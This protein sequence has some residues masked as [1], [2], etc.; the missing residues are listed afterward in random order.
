[1][2]QMKIIALTLLLA[3]TAFAADPAVEANVVYGMY[4]GAALL[5]DVHRPASPN[6][7]GIIYVSGSGWTSRWPTPRLR[8]SPTG[9]R[10]NMPSRWWRPDTPSSR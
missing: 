9:S 1:M 6:G 3:T 7:Y 8:S 2:A 10:C 5:L 4:S